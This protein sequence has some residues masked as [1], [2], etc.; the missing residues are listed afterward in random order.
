VSLIIEGQ[1][2]N[3]GAANVEADFHVGT[4]LTVSEARSQKPE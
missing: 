3:L 1:C 4:S 2:L